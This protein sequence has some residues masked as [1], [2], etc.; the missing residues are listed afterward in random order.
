MIQIL[1]HRCFWGKTHLF[2]FKMQDGRDYEWALEQIGKIYRKSYFDPEKAKG[3][4]HFVEIPKPDK[5]PKFSNEIKFK[6]KWGDKYIFNPKIN[7]IRWGANGWEYMIE[8]IGHK[9]DFQPE[10]K[11]VKI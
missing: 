6:V 1:T 4:L 7:A 2:D 11:L 9:H 10:S 3:D 5:W 8:N